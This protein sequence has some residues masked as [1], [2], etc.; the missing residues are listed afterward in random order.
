MYWRVILL[1]T[2]TILISS[3]IVNIEREDPSKDRYISV[4]V[5]GE[6]KDPGIYEMKLGST[7]ADLLNEAHLKEEGDTSQYSLNTVLYNKQVI[8]IGKHKDGL[9]SIN[10]A[11]LYELVSLPGIGP[12][13]AE[14]IIEYRNIYGSFNNLE[15]LMNVN[16]I[17]YGKFSKLKEY[18]CL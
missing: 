16:G 4:E 5:K 14:K 7:L 18:I 1:L 11:D 2:M 13:I 9:L 15:E 6:V 12:S 10:S 17:G 3:L 8:V